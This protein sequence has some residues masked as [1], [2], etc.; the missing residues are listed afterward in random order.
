MP[1]CVFAERDGIRAT[2]TRY[3]WKLTKNI[4]RYKHIQR[5]SPMDGGTHTINEG[6][7]I[8]RLLVASGLPIL[9]GPKR[10][11][12]G[13]FTHQQHAFPHLPDHKC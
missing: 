9:F 4:F 7:P 5:R 3:Y 13:G 1:L 6:A 11:H 12:S 10:S 8:H 2:D